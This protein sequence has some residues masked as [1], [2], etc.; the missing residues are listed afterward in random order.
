M[1]VSYSN[2]KIAIWSEICRLSDTR[3]E[4]LVEAFGRKRQT[5]ELITTVLQKFIASGWTLWVQWALG[6]WCMNNHY[7]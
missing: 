2:E 5:H 3:A 4:N 6:V 7:T 1:A